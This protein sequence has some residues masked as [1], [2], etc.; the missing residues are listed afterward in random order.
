MKLQ[1]CGGKFKRTQINIPDNLSGF[2]PAKS[3]VREAICNILQRKIEDSVVL[4]LCAGSGIFAMEMISRGA[5]RA[6]AVEQNSAL[7]NY[8]KKQIEKHSWSKDLEILCADAKHF[9]ENCGEKFDIIYFDPPYKENALSALLT[10]LPDLLNVDGIIVFEFA[11]DDKFVRENYGNY[12]FRKY[13]KSSV[14]FIGV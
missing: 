14:L 6:V 2:R 8:V 1:I 4:D 10:K 12:D 11:S 13:G 5:K 9:V 7:C 3:M